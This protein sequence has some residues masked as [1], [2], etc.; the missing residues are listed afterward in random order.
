MHNSYIKIRKSL[1]NSSQNIKERELSL[2]FL[3]KLTTREILV[4][5]QLDY[6][7]EFRFRSFKIYKSNQISLKRKIILGKIF[8]AIIFGILPIIPLL[9]YFE[10]LNRI[11]NDTSTIDIILFIGSLIFGIYFLLTLLNF[12]LL[13][14][15]TISRIISGQIFEWY[16]SL[17]ISEEKLKKL[18]I[19]TII[20]S[21]DIPLIVITFN[22]PVVMLIGTQNFLIFFVCLG[23]SI[24]NVLFCFSVIIL[25]GKKINQIMNINEI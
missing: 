5:E 22:L 1:K 9:T 15:L 3:S 13:S 12:L 19:L 25:F 7:G 16:R 10:V 17:P 18:L 20:R 8:G 23:V 11:I 24:L 21:I 2:F 4:E 6:L 14:M